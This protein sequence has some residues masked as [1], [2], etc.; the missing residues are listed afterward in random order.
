MV[1]C[2]KVAESLRLTFVP[3]GPEAPRDYGARSILR[4][5]Q[6]TRVSGFVELH[7]GSGADRQ[8]GRGGFDRA[9]AA[10]SRAGDDSSGGFV[11]AR[12]RGAMGNGH[13]E[14]VAAACETRERRA[15]ATFGAA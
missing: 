11:R 3:A 2:G 6:Q 7:H 10:G 5:S 4:Y 13:S 1:L 15:P 8:G 12:R 9:G 14:D